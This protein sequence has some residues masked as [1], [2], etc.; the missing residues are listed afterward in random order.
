MRELCELAYATQVCLLSGGDRER[1][2]Y[3]R[4]L[5]EVCL[6]ISAHPDPSW[7]Y[8]WVSRSLKRF[9]EP[10]SLVL[11]ELWSLDCNGWISGASITFPIAATEHPE[12]NSLRKEGLVWLMVWGC[13]GNRGGSSQEWVMP[14]NAQEP[15]CLVSLPL[16]KLAA[17]IKHLTWG[18][19]GLLFLVLQAILGDETYCPFDSEANWDSGHVQ[20]CLIV[21][22]M[23]KW[24][25]MSIP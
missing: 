19:S 13:P 8:M 23:R 11:E 12:K 17:E 16:I 22:S 10:G 9:P 7:S 21:D 25:Q 24:N 20:W 2:D 3:N 1:Q 15:V 4:S 5:S 14:R 6:W 18:P